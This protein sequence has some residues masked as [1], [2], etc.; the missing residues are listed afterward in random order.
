M[1][2]KLAG[3]GGKVVTPEQMELSRLQAGNIRLKQECEILKKRRRTSR[4][5]FSEV[6]LD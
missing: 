5:M 2:G 3:S 6:R 4:E 1:R